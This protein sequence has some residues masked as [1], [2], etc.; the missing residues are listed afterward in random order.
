MAKKHMKRCSP[1]SAIR[2]MHAVNNSKIP[3]TST[4]MTRRK[5]KEREIKRITDGEDL[6]N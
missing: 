2:K 3:L 6:E 4:R 1:S 5:K